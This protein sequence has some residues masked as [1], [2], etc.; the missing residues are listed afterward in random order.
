M[1]HLQDVSCEYTSTRIFTHL[2]FSLVLQN[3]LHSPFLRKTPTNALRY[4]NTILF[5][6][7]RCYMLQR[8]RDHPQGALIHF[9]IRV[10]KMRVRM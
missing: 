3:K 2:V 6:L 1:P 5:T 9:V 4:V 10:N 8:S 7:L